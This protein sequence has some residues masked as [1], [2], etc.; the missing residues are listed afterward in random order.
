MKFTSLFSL[1]LLVHLAVLG[2]LFVQPGCQ[3]TSAEPQAAQPSRDRAP[4]AAPTRAPERTTADSGR[5]QLDPAFNAGLDEGTARSAQPSR[6][7]SG[8]VAPTRPVQAEPTRTTT[9]ASRSGDGTLLQPFYTDDQGF[10][11]D[12][13]AGASNGVRSYNVRSGDTLTRIAEREGV[14]LEA[15]LRANQLDRNSTIYVDQTLTIPSASSAPAATA[16]TPSNGNGGSGRE[17]TVRSGDTLSAIATRHNVTVAQLRSANGISGDIIRVGQTLVIP[18]NGASTPAPTVAT[19]STPTPGGAT[20]TVRS[21]D[22]PGQIAR[23]FNVDTAELMRVNGISD[24]RRIRVG[25]VL[26][27]PGRTAD[28]SHTTESRPASRE[29]TPGTSESSDRD[30]VIRETTVAPR[31]I[32]G[33]PDAAPQPDIFDLELL[34]DED[35][36]Y[37]EVER[38]GGDN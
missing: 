4:T 34:D 1:I 16:T 14:T 32:N 5:S 25:Q 27:I 9:T 3:S 12:S 10:A 6:S 11:Q 31:R 36:P 35:L 30:P 24:P 8:L 20:Y 21:G 37:A 28:T 15:L 26:Q 33:Q 18:G 2:I 7:S 29:T 19:P 38:V 17:Y 22:T 23:Q 13:L